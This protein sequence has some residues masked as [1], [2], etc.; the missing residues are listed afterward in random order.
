ME[1]VPLVNIR[2]SVEAYL[3]QYYS[4]CIIKLV[5]FWSSVLHLY[6]LISLQSSLEP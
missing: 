6:W 2:H 3:W 1:K 5:G 4:T